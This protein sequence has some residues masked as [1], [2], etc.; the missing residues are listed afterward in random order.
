MAGLG[1]ELGSYHDVFSERRSVGLFE[2][3]PV[4]AGFEEGH[5]EAFSGSDA[6][7]VLLFFFVAG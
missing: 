5:V 4:V 7:H 1:H 3:S 6:D 2:G